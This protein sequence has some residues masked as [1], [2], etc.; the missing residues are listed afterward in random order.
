MQHIETVPI[1]GLL[2][3]YYGRLLQVVCDNSVRQDCG[4]LWEEGGSNSSPNHLS[5]V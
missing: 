1:Y 3:L 5:S 4:E 2:I